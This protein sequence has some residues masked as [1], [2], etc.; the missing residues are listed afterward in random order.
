MRHIYRFELRRNLRPLLVWG[1]CLAGLVCMGYMEFAFVFRSNADVTAIMDALPPQLSVLLGITAHVDFSTAPGFFCLMA[2]FAFYALSAYAILLGTGML[3]REEE[4][5][6]ADFL[7]ARPCARGEVLA[8][9]WLA[10]LTCC[11]LLSLLSVLVSALTFGAAAPGLAAA[12]AAWGAGLLFTQSLHFSAGALIA[13]FCRRPGRASVLSLLLLAATIFAG[14]FLAMAGIAGGPALA[15]S[16]RDY[17]PVERWLYGGG[18]GLWPWLLAGGGA[19]A[20]F[21]AALGRYRRKDL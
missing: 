9:K 21:A 17:F 1:L 13:A 3:A 20:L 7:Y 14:K 12:A 15:V 6:T 18:Y 4:E 10:G 19:A 8:G 11:F 2:D 5:R 16:P